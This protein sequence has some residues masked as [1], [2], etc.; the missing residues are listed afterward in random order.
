MPVCE[1]I[2]VCMCLLYFCI[3]VSLMACLLLYNLLCA[4]LLCVCVCVVCICACTYVGYIYFPVPLTVPMS[5]SPCFWVC[6]AHVP[7]SVHGPVF[8]CLCAC[9]CCVWHKLSAKPPAWFPILTSLSVSS[10]QFFDFSWAAS[11]AASSFPAIPI[12]QCSP[13]FLFTGSYHTAR[14]MWKPS[15]N[16]THSTVSQSPPG[17]GDQ[18]GVG[19]TGRDKE[20][21]EKLGSGSPG[22]PAA[23]LLF[24]KCG[25]Q[26]M[27]F[28]CFLQ[29]Q[30]GLTHLP[31]G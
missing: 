18:D 31:W 10:P 23:W 26:S 7:G 22:L 11:W 17:D 28:H 3:C 20:R 6:K 1:K 21:I 15:Y 27:P 24:Q 5:A 25:E 14:R 16:M 29:W 9:V 30:L 2:Y 13:S 12:F 19:E 4:C 8:A